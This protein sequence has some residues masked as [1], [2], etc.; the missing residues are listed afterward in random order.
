MTR[1]SQWRVLTS[2]YSAAFTLKTPSQGQ[3]IAIAI[4]I[5]R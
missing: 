1:I 4:A 5:H 3:S 2:S